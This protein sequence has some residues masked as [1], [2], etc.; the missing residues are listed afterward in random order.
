[1]SIRWM[2]TEG[3]ERQ[4]KIEKAE[5]GRRRK[6]EMMKKREN[7]RSIKTEEH[8]RRQKKIE[9]HRILKQT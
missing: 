4:K 2:K 8:G 5:T 1:M 3:D 7:R 9:K 6:T